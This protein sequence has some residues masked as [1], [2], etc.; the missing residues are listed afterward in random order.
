VN[1]DTR[2]RG[3]F[4]G[5]ARSGGDPPERRDEPRPAERGAPNATRHPAP[6]AH[7]EGSASAVA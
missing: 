2:G 6:E 3:A 7:E 1:D 4:G 5:M